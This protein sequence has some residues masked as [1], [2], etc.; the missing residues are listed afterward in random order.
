M[1]APVIAKDGTEGPSQLETYRQQE[2]GKQV[3]RQIARGTKGQ[4]QSGFQTNT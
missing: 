2:V 4:I 3:T 1:G